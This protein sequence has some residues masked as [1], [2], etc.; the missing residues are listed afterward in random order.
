[1]YSDEYES[2]LL[3]KIRLVGRNHFRSSAIFAVARRVKF[4]SRAG[5]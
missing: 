1:M 4:A 3:I 5:R 2:I